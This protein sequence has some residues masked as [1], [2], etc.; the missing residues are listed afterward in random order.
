MSIRIISAGPGKQG[1]SQIHQQFR[2][3]LFRRVLF[4]Q[5]A[6]LARQRSS[7][8]STVAGR[9]GAAS[10]SRPASS[11]GPRYS[12]TPQESWQA[13]FGN[14]LLVSD[15]A[16]IK[17]NSS[18]GAVPRALR[19]ELGPTAQQDILQ[20]ILDRAFLLCRASRDE[21]NPERPQSRS[22]A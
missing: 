21:R 13:D 12:G 18:Q 14:Q 22:R 2:G 5:H 11:G 3:L 9:G 19:Q 1:N 4:G 7:L 16:G 8:Q 6:H 20:E 17:A 15:P 10:Q